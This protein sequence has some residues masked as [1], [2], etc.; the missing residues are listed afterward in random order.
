[1]AKQKD[2]GAKKCVCDK[3]MFEGHA[4]PN[5]V[6]R[7]CS[8]NAESNTPRRKGDPIPKPERGIWK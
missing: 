7:R 5:K 3:C 2:T 6:H 1:M 4:I 8:G